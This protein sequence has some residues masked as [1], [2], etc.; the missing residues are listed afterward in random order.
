MAEMNV[1]TGYLEA[2]S[3]V[4]EY[5]GSQ[6]AYYCDSVVMILES[7]LTDRD[8]VHRQTAS[9][10]VK[11][12][13]LGLLFHPARKVREVYWR[14]YNALYLSAADEPVPFYPDLG[15]LTELLPHRFLAFFPS[16]EHMRV[17][18]SA[19]WGDRAAYV[20]AIAVA[21]ANARVQ[22]GRWHLQHDAVDGV[23]VA[24][25]FV[26]GNLDF[27]SSDSLLNFHIDICLSLRKLD[28]NMKECK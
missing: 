6:S 12:L 13:A 11:H 3:F 14:I 15:E 10:I 4:F 17:A 5:V 27:F 7:A 8:L 24:G 21:I 23:R 26:D 18:C 2:L 22:P 20:V 28:L 9:T 25:S 16:P 19:R 1:W